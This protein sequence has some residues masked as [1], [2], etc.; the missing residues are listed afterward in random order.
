MI[1]PCVVSMEQKTNKTIK[2][3]YKDKQSV[4]QV[5]TEAEGENRLTS[6]IDRYLYKVTAA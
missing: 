6:Y 3:N 5:K 2:D 4:E 1:G